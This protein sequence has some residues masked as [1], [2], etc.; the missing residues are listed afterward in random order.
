MRE[1]LKNKGIFHQGPDPTHPPPFMETVKKMKNESLSW[2][3][4]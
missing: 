2:N 1:G 3:A 4:F